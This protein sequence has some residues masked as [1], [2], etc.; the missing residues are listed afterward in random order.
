M[1]IDHNTYEAVTHLR[2]RLHQCPEPSGCEKKT[3]E[4]LKAFLKKHTSMEIIEK[5]GWFYAVH[6]EGHPEDSVAFRAD[7]DAIRGE[8]GG[9]FHGC[10]HDGHSAVLAGLGLLLEGETVGKDVYLIFQPSEET[11]QGA[12][13]CSGLIDEKGIREIYGF[14]NLP[15][16]PLGK[17]VLKKGTFACASKGLILSL[18]GKQSHAA[19][20]E[21]GINPAWLIGEL[22]VKIPELLHAPH[23]TGMVLATIVEVKLGSQSF[24]VSPGE[25]RISLT[26]RGEKLEDLIRFEESVV[27]FTQKQ[28][29]ERLIEVRISSTE[30]FPDTVNEADMVNRC[31]QKLLEQEIPFMEIQ[32]PFRWSEDFGWYLKKTQGMFFGVGA[33]ADC[34]GLHTK[35]YEFP[36]EVIKKALLSM[37][38]F[39]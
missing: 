21:Q 37:K 25:G 8:D 15:G 3:M 35:D 14:H 36:D 18:K 2:R 27:S 6:H 23:F 11:G 39:L 19:Y 12:V 9:F 7:M 13:L 10:G 32:E 26:L 16:Y 1:N 4:I 29:A 28:A 22:I 30:E 33:G 31:G 24:G 20:P 34:P 17:A 5:T 38:A